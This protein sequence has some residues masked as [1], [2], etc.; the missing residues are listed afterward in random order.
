MGITSKVKQFFLLHYAVIEEIIPLWFAIKK[1]LFHD[2]ILSMK[3][4]CFGN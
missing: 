4:F 3:T 2:N 1:T